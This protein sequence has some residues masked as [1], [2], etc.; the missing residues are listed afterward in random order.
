MSLVEEAYQHAIAE[1]TPQARLRR[2]HE[3]LAWVR[4]LYAGQAIERLGEV[5]DERLKLEV[6]LRMYGSEPNMRRLLEQRLADVS[7]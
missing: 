7:S 6:A 1:M 2:M 5:S 3:L 4:E